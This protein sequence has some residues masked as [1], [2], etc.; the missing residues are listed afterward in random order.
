MF[1]ILDFTLSPCIS[2]DAPKPSPLNIH[3]SL[4]YSLYLLT[5]RALH[6]ICSHFFLSFLHWDAPKSM[7]VDALCIAISHV[8]NP[9]GELFLSLKTSLLRWSPCSPGA[10]GK[11][12]CTHPLQVIQ[13]AIVSASGFQCFFSCQV[14]CHFPPLPQHV[15]TT[16]IYVI[17]ETSWNINVQS[18][19]T[20]KMV[21]FKKLTDKILL[22]ASNL[23]EWGSLPP[24]KPA[25]NFKYLTTASDHTRCGTS[26]PWEICGIAIMLSFQLRHTLIF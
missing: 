3:I 7:C 8:S 21:A 16:S 23:F 20:N 13:V 5:N 26:F 1:Q 25:E 15:F 10:I 19:R 9:E 24:L 22:C 6:W 4:K 11:T 17:F 12:W 18:W 14:S 2:E